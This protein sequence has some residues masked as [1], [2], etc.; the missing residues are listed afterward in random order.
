EAAHFHRPLDG[1][2]TAG[3][4]QAAAALPGN[5]DNAKIQ[6]RRESAVD[7][8]FRLA[9]GLAPVQGGEIEK[10][11]ANRALDLEGAIPGQEH[12]RRMGVDAPYR[13]ARVG[14]RVG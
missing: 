11:I 9:R 7:L 8:E 10:R 5:R 14:R 13:T 6:F 1:R 2:A 12:R 4:R 3:E